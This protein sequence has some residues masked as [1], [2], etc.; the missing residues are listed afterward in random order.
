MV[1]TEEWKGNKRQRSALRQKFAGRCAYCGC[2]LKDMHADHLEPVVRLNTDPWG[3]R[4]PAA[5]CS[6]LKP[7][8]NV[9]ANM[10][11]ACKPCNL[12]KGGYPL[13][14]WRDVIQRSAEI[15]R[16]QTS[17]FK[18]GERF[19]VIAVCDAPVLFYFER[20]TL[21]HQDAEASSQ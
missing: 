15:V 19:G 5:E 1:E 21:G 17:T 6:L 14:V 7:E 11:P 9:V 18:A 12:H 4:L 2:E 10:M 16:K 20:L 8:R 3:R 13:E